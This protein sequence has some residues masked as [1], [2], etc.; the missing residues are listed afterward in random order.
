M[1]YEEA[2]V[3]K[4]LKEEVEMPSHVRKMIEV[5]KQTRKRLSV[6]PRTYSDQDLTDVVIQFVG[7]TKV[8]IAIAAHQT[9]KLLKVD[10]R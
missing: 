3:D 5:S 2:A 1:Q 8:E 10:H 6:G 4:Y 7:G 9:E